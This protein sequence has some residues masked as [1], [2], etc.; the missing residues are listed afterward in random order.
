MMK[1]SKGLGGALLP[2]GSNV[3]RTSR[4]TSPG[5]VQPDFR[6]NPSSDR[7][8]SS[9]SRTRA[10]VAPIRGSEL[11]S[12]TALLYPFPPP[13]LS[14]PV[15][16][17]SGV[18]ARSRLRP[19]AVGGSAPLT[20]GI[21]TRPAAGS[22]CYGHDLQEACAWRSVTRQTGRDRHRCDTQTVHNGHPRDVRAS[23][24]PIEL[25]LMFV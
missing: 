20:I 17:S 13:S 18:M 22:P 1:E 23:R 14:T 12:I 24:P 25:D 10:E 8:S 11:V 2:F 19:V 21:K 16:G 3:A 7:S 4:I 15:S 9:C 6:V 5:M